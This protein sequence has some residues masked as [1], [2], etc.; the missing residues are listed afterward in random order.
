MSMLILLV[1]EVQEIYRQFSP[2]N[3]TDWS[4]IKKLGEGKVE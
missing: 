2:S 4:I 1:I 3:S